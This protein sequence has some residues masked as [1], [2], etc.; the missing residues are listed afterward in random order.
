MFAGNIAALLLTFVLSLFYLANRRFVVTKSKY[1]PHSLIFLASTAFLGI[2]ADLLVA[3]LP[4]IDGL[5]LFVLSLYYLGTLLAFAYTCLYL[6]SRILGNAKTSN[7]LKQSNLVVLFLICT[8]VMLLLLNI[9]MGILFTLENGVFEKGPLYGW[10]VLADTMAL[11]LVV[12]CYVRKRRYVSRSLHLTLAQLLPVLA[13]CIVLSA[14]LASTRLCS[15]VLAFSQVLIYLNFRSTFVGERSLALL[16]TRV[17]F[18]R[19]TQFFLDR[20]RPIQLF[21]VR[22]Q[23]LHSLKAQY[24]ATLYYEIL[25]RFAS[26]LTECVEYAHAYRI[27]ECDF[28]LCTIPSKKQGREQIRESV[29]AL[30]RA[31]VHVGEL[32]IKPRCTVVEYDVLQGQQEA[33]AVYESMRCAADFA[34]ANTEDFISYFDTYAPA[35]Q[36]RAHINDLVRFIDREHGYAITLQ[37]VGNVAQAATDL[38]RARVRF[39]ADDGVD[40]TPDEL[41]RAI[42]SAGKYH[43]LVYFVLEEVCRTM[44]ENP[45]LSHMRALIDLPLPLLNDGE[46]LHRI[47]EITS[48]YRISHDRIVF[49]MDE[50]ITLAEA[51][52]RRAAVRTLLA[53]DYGLHIVNFGVSGVNLRGLLLLTPRCVWLSDSL[54][55]SFTESSLSALVQLLHESGLTVGI[56]LTACEQDRVCS[57]GASDYYC[58]DSFAPHM[59]VEDLLVYLRAKK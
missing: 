33:G 52:E 22:V 31:G 24:G 27:S 45:E 4:H 40:V 15:M 41:M 37:P 51:E 36:Q 26:E 6:V 21:L 56:D 30:A 50:A 29:Q 1:Y 5:C 13:F 17:G 42:A 55:S 7:Y 47:N 23:D 8:Y 18:V 48:R 14:L 46:L 12:I 54:A 49:A 20:S 53:M 19:D 28:L 32:E 3:Y 57:R 39:L 38:L 44:A 43:A 2:V 25:F 34:D 59:S 35:M 58:A 9:P 11:A 16:G 10:D